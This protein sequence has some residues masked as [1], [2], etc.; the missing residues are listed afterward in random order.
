MV[1]PITALLFILGLGYALSR[2]KNIKYFS[3]LVW[4]SLTFIFGGILTA[5]PP[6]W[7]HL[8]IALPAIILTAAVGAKS[9]SEKITILFGQVGYK[10][11]SWVL[12][13]VI[14]ITGISNW[15]IYYDY[16][17]NNAS[18]RIRI[19]RYLASLP[20]GYNVYLASSDWRWNED[21]FRFYNQGMTGQDLTSEMLMTAPPVISQPTVFILFRHPE[22]Q[23]ILQKLYP[24]GI[25][26][27]HY[28]Y[29]NLISFTSFSVVPPEYDLKPPP[30]LINPLSLPGWLLIFGFVMYYVGFAAYQHYSSGV[31]KS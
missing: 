5:D 30:P 24:N 8:N 14:V 21:A 11:Y 15:Q 26:E 25:F 10:V 17:K 16:V 29:N 19:S 18:N 23:P 13:S 9:L 3:I 2:I 4:I 7:P 31:E 12:V 22:L 6:Y 20:P 28:D 27:N 1:D